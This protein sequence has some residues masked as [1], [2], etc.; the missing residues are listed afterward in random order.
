[1][2]KDMIIKNADTM[3]FIKAY[4]RSDKT[5]KVIIILNGRCINEYEVITSK[6]IEND[7]NIKDYHIYSS[8]TY[9]DFSYGYNPLKDCKILF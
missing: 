8:V 4:K 3:K 9:A 6:F 1:M 2:S 7:L 5:D